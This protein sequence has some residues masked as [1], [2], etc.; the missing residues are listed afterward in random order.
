MES[1]AELR[2][3]TEERVRSLL[4]LVTNK[5]RWLAALLTETEDAMACPGTTAARRSE[6]GASAAVVRA[7]MAERRAGKAH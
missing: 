2:A 7:L 3:A 4:A 6:L 5:D 1:D